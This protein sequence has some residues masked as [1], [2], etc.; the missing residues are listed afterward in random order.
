[1]FCLFFLNK[2]KLQT[3]RF[4]V[5]VVVVFLF[6]F[7]PSASCFFH[8]H[9]SSFSRNNSLYYYCIHHTIKKPSP[10]LP[11]MSHS[12]KHTV[13]TPTKTRK[14]T[15]KKKK[16]HRGCDEPKREMTSVGWYLYIY[17]FECRY[18]TDDNVVWNNVYCFFCCLDFK[19]NRRNEKVTERERESEESQSKRS[20]EIRVQLERWDYEEVEST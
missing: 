19:T 18:Y 11:K 2:R 10:P 6:S 13:T 15:K 9:P 5:V 14:K 20:S 1:M 17:I 8:P 7:F 4:V 3:K 16:K 12:T